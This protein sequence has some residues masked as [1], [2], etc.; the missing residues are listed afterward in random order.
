M[1]V[2]QSLDQR[3]FKSKTS[4]ARFLEGCTAPGN[5]LK[6]RSHQLTGIEFGLDLD[7]ESMSERK[8]I[9]FGLDSN[10]PNRGV[11]SKMLNAHIISYPE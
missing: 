8:E 6:V 1:Y 3:L 4:V 9:G 7:N 2:Y 10:P 11:L 5:W